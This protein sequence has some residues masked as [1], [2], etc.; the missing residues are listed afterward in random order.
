MSHTGP[1]LILFKVVKVLLEGRLE[2]P[3]VMLLLLHYRGRGGSAMVLILHLIVGRWAGEQSSSVITG[4]VQGRDS[5]IFRAD[6]CRLV[7]L[8]WSGVVSP[9]ELRAQQLMSS[10]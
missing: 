8:T 10:H 9:A 6:F 2:I 5:T 7:L 1:L 3:V 4:L